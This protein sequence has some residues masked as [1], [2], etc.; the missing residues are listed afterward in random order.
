M[1]FVHDNSKQVMERIHVH[2]ASDFIF[3]FR[4]FSLIYAL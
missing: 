3:K 4:I 2:H 1:I